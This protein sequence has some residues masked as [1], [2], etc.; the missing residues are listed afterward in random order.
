MLD[1]AD[2]AAGVAGAQDVVAEAARRAGREPA[3]VRDRR[4]GQVRRRATTCRRCTRPASAARA[5]TARTS[6][7]PSRRHTAS[8]S[9]GTSSGT[10]RAARCATSSVASRSCT[11]WSRTPRPRSSSRARPTPQDVLVEVNTAA[12]P[13]KYGVAPADLDAFLERLAGLAQVAGARPDD[14]AGARARPR[15]T[16]ARPSPPCARPARRRLQRWDGDARLRR[17]LDGHQPG[18]R[19]GRRGGRDAG[20]ARERASRASRPMG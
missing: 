3:D 15:R 4:G 19:G 1:P 13:S 2:I 6:W 14:D 20:A 7:R 10:C 8:S 5:R 18:L 11:R 9:R 12:D 17:A 16:R